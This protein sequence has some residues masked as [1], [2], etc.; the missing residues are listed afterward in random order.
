L[1]CEHVAADFFTS[2]E[3]WINFW[4]TEAV[5]YDV[6]RSELD[7]L[8]SDTKLDIAILGVAN[9]AARR[10]DSVRPIGLADLGNRTDY[11]KARN[12]KPTHPQH[13]ICG[14]SAQLA[15]Y[16]RTDLITMRPMSYGTFPCLSHRPNQIMFEYSGTEKGSSPPSAP[17][18]SGSLVWELNPARTGEIWIPGKAVAMQNA[19]TEGRRLIC[20]PIYPLRKWITENL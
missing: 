2:K 8:Y 18:L 12:A 6:R 20:S 5:S 1:T 19:W 17:G 13:G 16:A 7:I 11:L 14:W 10:L 15:K 3:G 4:R 9:R